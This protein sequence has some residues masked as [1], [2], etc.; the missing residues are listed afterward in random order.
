M[1]EGKLFLLISW[2]AVNLS[3]HTRHLTATEN[4]GVCHF[5]TTCLQEQLA[6]ARD[7]LFFTTP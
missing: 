5:L 4:F 6:I 2:L 7:N 1:I 3:F